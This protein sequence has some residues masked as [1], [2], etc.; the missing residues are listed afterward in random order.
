MARPS[1]GLL[2]YRRT[3]GELEVLLVHPGGPFWRAKDDGAW[4]L[5]KG[6]IEP[7]EE[8][9]AAARREFREEIGFE[10][11]G[12]FTPLGETRHKS[13]KRVSAWAF[14][15]NWD[16]ALLASNTFRMEWPPNSGAQRE[17]PEID[18]AEFFAIDAARRKMHAA[19]AVFLDRLVE[20]L[21][22]ARPH[23]SR[24]TSRDC[25][26]GGDLGHAQ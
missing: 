2:L 10:P 4:F 25:G 9:L 22:G 24:S 21:S 16:T 5:P 26:D 19:E 20:H 8:P 11:E 14:A 3:R 1:A 7:N 15:G 17:F 23:D 6:E 13:G 12:P 18:R